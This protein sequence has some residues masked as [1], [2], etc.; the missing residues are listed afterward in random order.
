MNKHITATEIRSRISRD[1][2]Y[3]ARLFA[4]ILL[5]MLDRF[6]PR[7]CHREVADVLMEAALKGGLELTSVAMRKQYEA[8]MLATT[9]RGLSGD[10][11]NRMHGVDDKSTT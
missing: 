11:L 6:I 4:N 7:A 9:L 3:A 1:D 10:W 8:V 2:E 5:G